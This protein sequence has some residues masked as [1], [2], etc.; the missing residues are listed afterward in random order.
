MKW[1]NGLPPLMGPR[2]EPASCAAEFVTRGYEGEFALCPAWDADLVER[3][4]LAGFM[5]LSARLAAW[6]EP[7]TALLPKLHVARCLMDPV[8]TRAG[9]TVARE[10][11]RYTLSAN[12]RFEAVLAACVAV[13]GEDWLASELVAAFCRLHAERA[14][15]TVRF[16][17]FELSRDGEMV[18]GEFGY[19]VGAS[20]AS[21]SGFRTVSGAGTV[22]LA[23]LGGLLA[24][25]G[26]RVWDL[27]MPVAYKAAL[28][29]VEYPRERYLRLLR[30]AYA[31]PVPALVETMP[32]VPAGELV[33][34]LRAATAG[35][36]CK[37]DRRIV[38]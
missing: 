1:I 6:P 22:Q 27:G 29:S 12:A 30:T 3:V 36:A 19:I 34:A 18:A 2:D 33:A 35:R 5:P 32:P 26:V 10:S 23:A 7:R 4:A 17:S 20:Y 28:G 31:G 37:P 11:R 14:A 25:S 16:V 9:S 24:G 13:H 21:L 15:R 38:Q 8:R